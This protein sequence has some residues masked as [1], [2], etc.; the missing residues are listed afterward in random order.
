M[1]NSCNPVFM[2]TAKLLRDA[3]PEAWYKYLD[4]FGFGKKTAVNFAGEA[5]GILPEKQRLHFPCNI[6]HWTRY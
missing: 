1:A 2:D 4:S 6:C 5:S 3:N